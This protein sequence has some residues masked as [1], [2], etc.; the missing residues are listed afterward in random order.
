MGWTSPLCPNPTGALYSG[1]KNVTNHSIGN[2]IMELCMFIR[3]Y[4]YA[5]VGSEQDENGGGRQVLGDFFN[6]QE[7]YTA[8]ADMGLDYAIAKQELETRFA[9]PFSIEPTPPESTNS[10]PSGN[11]TQTPSGDVTQTSGKSSSDGHRSGTLAPESGAIDPIHLMAIILASLM[12]IVALIGIVYLCRNRK[13]VSSSHNS[14]PSNSK[15][16]PN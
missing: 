6:V 8:Y 2:L 4:Y 15:Q 13:P 9:V 12:I 11:D 5:M 1:E 10:T 14:L 16:V 3:G 7:C